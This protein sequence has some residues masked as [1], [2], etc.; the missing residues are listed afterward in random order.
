ML[1]LSPDFGQRFPMEFRRIANFGY[2][3]ENRPTAASELQVGAR[4]HEH[5]VMHPR[6]VGETTVHVGSRGYRWENCIRKGNE[7]PQL[8]NYIRGV[9]ACNTHPPRLTRSRNHDNAINSIFLAIIVTAALSVF[10]LNCI[11]SVFVVFESC[12]PM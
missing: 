2:Q 6:P 12:F 1:L 11:S 10:Q 4:Y 8:S 5:S 7:L 3:V 9:D